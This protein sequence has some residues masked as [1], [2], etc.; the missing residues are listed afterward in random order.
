MRLE[1]VF[2]DGTSHERTTISAENAYRR[3][4]IA[5]PPR[6]YKPTAFVPQANRAVFGVLRKRVVK[7]KWAPKAG[8]PSRAEGGHDVPNIALPLAV[9]SSSDTRRAQ[10]RLKKPCFQVLP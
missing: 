5:M 6:S 8:L 3:A 2:S 4:E 1:H 7:P 10:I 9:F